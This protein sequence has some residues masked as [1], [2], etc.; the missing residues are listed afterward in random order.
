MHEIDWN[1]TKVWDDI[2][3][4]N[5]CIFQMESDF[6]GST[7]NTMHPKNIFEMSL[8]NAMIRPSGA[9]YR[10]DLSH[11]II[12]HNPDRRIDE[13]LKNNLG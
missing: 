6:A 10:N 13:L 9:S 12:K 3:D 1:D 11:R 8:V 2:D 4:N 5:L 7:M